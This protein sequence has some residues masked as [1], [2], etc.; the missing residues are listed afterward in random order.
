MATEKKG[1]KLFDAVK[2]VQDAGFQLQVRCHPFEDRALLVVVLERCSYVPFEEF[3]H[4]GFIASPKIEGK[5]L[6]RF[7]ADLEK[8]VANKAAREAARA[9]EAA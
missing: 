7:R 2:T 1:M 6:E 3:T 8:A 9:S 4:F 5:E